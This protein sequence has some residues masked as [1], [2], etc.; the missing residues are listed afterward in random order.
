MLKQSGV[1]PNLPANTVLLDNA[2][3]AGCVTATLLEALKRDSVT[4]D[5][6]GRTKIVCGEIEPNMLKALEQRVTENGWEKIVEVKNVDAL[7]GVIPFW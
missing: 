4:L 7:V 6:L 3:G 2:A 1:L 5:T